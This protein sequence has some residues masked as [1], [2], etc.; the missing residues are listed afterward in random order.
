[1]EG[2]SEY[3][4]GDL[5]TT[6]RE[7]FLRDAVLSGGLLPVEQLHS[8]NHVAPHQVTLAYKESEAFI[9]YIS[10]EYGQ[11]KLPKLLLVDSQGIEP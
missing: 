10:E 3:V 5:D 9:R 1:M 6:T 11:D 8:F 2:L 4:S 7:M